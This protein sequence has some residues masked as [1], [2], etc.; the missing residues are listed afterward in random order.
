MCNAMLQRGEER[1]IM[2]LSRAQLA[3]LT[4]AVRKFHIIVRRLTA[5]LA[6]HPRVMHLPCC[7]LIN[8]AQ[9]L[10][11]AYQHAQPFLAVLWVD[12]RCLALPPMFAVR[13]VALLMNVVVNIAPV[14]FAPLQA[15]C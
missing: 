14:L 5:M 13:L 10:T 9:T 1:R 2:Q 11:A 8:N 15:M 3:L 7:V 6:G 4:P 12:L